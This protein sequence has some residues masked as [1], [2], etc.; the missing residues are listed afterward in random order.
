MASCSSQKYILVALFLSIILLGSRSGNAQMVYTSTPSANSNNIAVTS[1]IELDFDTDINLSSVHS[2]TT[3]AD[4]VLDD[5]IKIVGSQNG[6]YRGVFSVGADNSIVIFNPAISF[7]AG[8]RI[9]V[10]VNALVLGAG[11]EVAVARSFSFIAASGPFEGAFLER[12]T[13]GIGGIV[14][15]NSDWGDYD[16]DGDLDLVLVGF[17]PAFNPSATIYNN[18]NGVFTPI[19]AGLT[20][21]FDAACEWGDYDGDGDLDLFIAGLDASFVTRIAKIYRNDG[22]ATFTDIGAA[23]TGVDFASIDWGDYDND[24]DLDLVIAG[25]YQFTPTQLYSTVIYRNDGA[26]VFTDIGASIVG[27]TD[28]SADW[29][30]YDADGDLDL[31]ITGFDNTFGRHFKIYS[32]NA[33]VFTEIGAG[34][35][36]F[37]FSAADWGDYDNDGDLDIAVLGGKSSG[38]DGAFIYQNNAGVFTDINAG[39]PDD[40]EEGSIQW[41]DYDGDGDLDLLLTGQD[42]SPGDNITSAIFRNDA[43][44]FTNIQAG[45]EGVTFQSV[46]DWMDFD[47]DGDLDLFVAGENIPGDIVGRLYENTVFNAFVTTWKTDNPGS[48]NSDQITIPTTGSGY[49]YR[50]DWGD[51][52]FDTDVTGDIT[53][54]YASAGTYTVSITGAFPRIFFNAGSFLPDKD[55]QKIL[56]VEQWGNVQWASM[57]H[58]FSGCENLR[59]NAPDAPDLSGVTDMTRMFFD[60]IAFNDNINHWDVSNVSNMSG[61]FKDAETFNQSLNAWDVSNVTNM[62]EMFNFA[63][64]FNQDVRFVAGGANT[65]GDAWNTSN[66]LDMGSMFG[67]ASAFDQDIGNWNVNNVTDMNQIFSVAV[68]FNQ[69]IGNWN[70]SNVTDIRSMFNGATAFNQN[71]ST[72]IGGGNYG[73]DAWNTAGINDMSNMFRNATAFDQNIGNWDVGQVNDMRSMFGFAGAFNQDIS[74]WN[75][76]NVSDFNGMFEDATSFNQAIGGWTTTSAND[77]RNMFDGAVAFDQNLGGWDI[78]NLSLAVNMLRNSRVSVANYDNLLTGW[79]S[80]IGSINTSVN[81]GAQGLFYCAGESARAALIGLGWTITDAGS[82]CISLFDGP[83]TAAPEITNAQ[84][85][86]IDFGSTNTLK[87]RAFTILNNQGMAITNVQVDNPGPGFTTAL[88][89]ANIAAG[90]TQTFT[91]DLTGAIGTYTE[92][93]TITS[94]DFAGSFTFDVTG[95]I[96]VGPQ[97]EIKVFE[98]PTITGNEILDGFSLYDIGTEFRG[99]DITTEITILNLGSADLNVA[100][101]SFSGTAFSVLSPTSLT[102]PADGSEIVQ[103][104]LTGAQGGFFAELL[105]IENDDANEASFDFA[106]QGTIIGPDIW[107]VDGTDIFSDPEITNGQPTA[108]D[109]G[110]SPSGS[111]VVRQFT[112]TDNTEVALAISTISI[113]GTAFSFTPAPPINIAGVVDGIYDEVL[114]TITLSGAAPGTFTETVTITS[115]DDAD[116]IFQ[117]PITGTIVATACASIPT[118]AAG[119]DATVCSGAAIQLAGAIGGGA[120][121]ATWSSN[122]TGT[123]DNNSILNAT[124]LP[125]NAD[126]A[127]GSVTLTLT[128]PA[129][130]LCPMVQDQLVLSIP[131]PVVGGSPAVQSNVGQTTT[132]DVVAASNIAPSDVQSV[133]VTAPAS[134]GTASVNP[135]NTINY[136]PN[137]GTVGADSFEYEICDNCGIC[138]KAIVSIDILNAAPTITPPS[139]PLTAVAGQSVL[140]PLASFISDLN[141]NIDFNSIKVTNGPRSNA[142]ASFDAN[143]DLTLDYSNTPFAG[144]DQ[145]TIEVCDFLNAC[146]QITLEIEVDG[147]IVVHNGISP[148][149]DGKNDYFKIENIQFLEPENK[150]S[151]F[152]RWGDRVFEI[153]NY[154]SSIESKRFNGLSDSGKEL[155]SGIYFYHIVFTSGRPGL[156]GYLTLKR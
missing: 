76:A 23:V 79:A 111:D 89:I 93:I 102:I 82:K 71:I 27:V 154:D 149:E 126:I 55:A 96:T 127:S 114:F 81:F 151:I 131:A 133:T 5:N 146:A 10:V 32:N 135:D 2:N 15:G 57:A 75:V 61:L 124:Y 42:Y 66:V 100:N 156:S 43:G 150:V 3:N 105:T 87:T 44:I 110:S 94:P 117:F 106:V 88:V 65:G 108:I 130:G 1:N 113:T 152:N 92:T 120:S 145:I 30:D 13:A 148:N 134:L 56:S 53:H 9:T 49:F 54:T 67:G 98:G 107:V 90:A 123:F 6:Q 128:V 73:G 143:Y 11:G 85:Q 29:G 136:V 129:N 51:G 4:D 63:R 69:D 50:V 99:T 147:E 58:A 33:G 118:V 115:D 153:G 109:F 60:A 17:D 14:Y 112:I 26:G 80:Q 116:P 37:G 101:I 142:V 16:N 52:T 41:G 103:I 47:G 7:N 155:A 19:P 72:K 140:I 48:S 35:P 31:L 39:L 18:V 59:I 139:T 34:L 25:R 122:G 104:Q 38:T 62:G 28:G 20:G 22:G 84:T 24:G 91:V 46:G 77:M 97:P 138:S 144:T 64:A 86:A 8:E 36:G 74:G 70:I 125:S 78:T 137:A 12:T 141:N 40:I 45:L 68:A 21:V 83:N 121:A 119:A 95:E 132:V